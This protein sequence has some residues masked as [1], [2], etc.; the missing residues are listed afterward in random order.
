MISI[1]SP[2]RRG[3]AAMRCGPECRHAERLRSPYAEWV[4][5]HRHDAT[6]RLHHERSWC[7]HYSAGS[8]DARG[9]G[10]AAAAFQRAREEAAS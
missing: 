6:Q 7:Q 5:C 9:S 1:P 3:G 2:G 10:R 4:W 8:R